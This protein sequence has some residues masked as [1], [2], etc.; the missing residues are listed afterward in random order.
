MRVQEIGLVVVETAQR[1]GDGREEPY[2]LFSADRME[3]PRCGASALIAASRPMVSWES[4]EAMST[5]LQR[6]AE[7][8]KLVGG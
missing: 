1:G 2:K 7:A 3:C 6:A 8:G 4:P 5:A